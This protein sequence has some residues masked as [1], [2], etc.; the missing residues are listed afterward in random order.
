MKKRLFLVL[1]VV[2][3]CMIMSFSV[4][5]AEDIVW[6][7]DDNTVQNW[8]IANAG[9]HTVENGVLKLNL[10]ETTYDIQIKVP[11]SVSTSDYK[12]IIIDMKHNVPDGNMGNNPFEVFFRLTGGSWKQS[13][14]VNTTIAPASDS[15][16]RYTIDLSSNS[17][18]TGTINALRIDPIDTVSVSGSQYCV[19]IDKITFVAEETTEE[20]GVIEWNFDNGDRQGWSVSNGVDKGITDG[21][22]KVALS[23]TKS[24]TWLQNTSV[25]FEAAPYKY[26]V[27]YMRHNLPESNYGNDDFFALFA[28]T[29]DTPWQAHLLAKTSTRYASSQ[30][31]MPYIV[32]MTKCSYW[33]GSIKALRIDPFEAKSSSDTE[34]YFEVDKILMSYDVKLT[35]EDTEYTVPAGVTVNLSDY[36]APTKAGFVFAGW[37]D[38]VSDEVITKIAIEGDTTLKAKWVEANPKWDFDDNTTQGWLTNVDGTLTVENGALKVLLHNSNNDVFIYTQGQS[39]NTSVYKYAVVYMKHNVPESAWDS[40]PVQFLFY[41]SNSSWWANML[42]NADR[43]PASNNY[44]EYIFNMGSNTYWTGVIP[45]LR[46]D[47]FQITAPSLGDYVVYIDK[48]VMCPEI[49]LTLDYGFDDISDRTYLLPGGIEKS[50][51]VYGQPERDGYRF[52]GW[53]DAEGNAVA[54]V[55]SSSDVTLYA[56]WKPTT[57]S[58]TLTTTAVSVANLETSAKLVLSSYDA[59]GRVMD[60]VIVPVSADMSTT[61]ASSGLDTFQCR[62]IRAFLFDDMESLTPLCKEKNVLFYMLDYEELEGETVG[63]MGRWFDYEHSDG[64]TYKATITPGAEMFFK[65]SGTANV[66]FKLNCNSNLHDVPYIA[67]SIDGGT[68]ERVRTHRTNAVTIASGLDAEKEHYIRIIVDSFSSAQSSRWTQG[69]GLIFDKVTVDAGGTITGLMPKNP[70]IAYYGD[71]ITEGLAA[72]S[73][74]GQGMYSTS[75]SAIS[76]YPFTASHLVGAVSHTNGY[77]STGITVEKGLGSVPNCITVIDNMIQDTPIVMPKLD[78]IV[79]NHGHND[80]NINTSDAA[81]GAAYKEVLERLREKHPGVPILAVVP[82]AQRYVEAIRGVVEEMNDDRIYYIS[83]AGWEYTTLDGVHPDAAGAEKLGTKLAAE[84]KRVLA[85]VKAQGEN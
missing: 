83:T 33:N 30:G 26:M 49:K 25:S 45:R 72:L 1:S 34:Y 67:V 85:D 3:I 68:P 15:F 75:S 77:G 80:L 76:A 6:N 64:N 28:R 5:A 35:L 7:F 47:P 59:K 27:V 55:N 38:G 19:E 36:S 43:K 52:L 81:F 74:E 24:D 40:T 10:S 84:I 69:N 62:E 21:V 32:D 22:Y 9:S 57:P 13:H 61:F 42:V 46:I 12:T 41:N 78:A 70:T 2:C 18:Y 20:A 23:T 82:Y 63:F 31:F 65:V 50:L 58:I 29:T 51:A 73:T 16:H 37:T 39:V 71:S 14:S 11:V 60:T 44:E 8:V 4:F 53:V 48:I 17:S 54:A 79:I 56:S 66:N